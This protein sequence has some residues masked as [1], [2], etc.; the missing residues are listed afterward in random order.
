MKLGL[1]PASAHLT[2]FGARRRNG[3][4]GDV[5]DFRHSPLTKLS[6]KAMIKSMSH[7]RSWGEALSRNSLCGGE[8]ACINGGK[9]AS[10]FT[11]ELALNRDKKVDLGVSRAAGLI[12]NWDVRGVKNL[13]A[14]KTDWDDTCVDKGRAFS[15]GI[16]S[17]FCLAE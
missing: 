10:K 7:G 9:S 17:A 12:V 8:D 15:L 14:L 6:P 13:E 11:D 16:F 5:S 1:R 3:E 4:A 2:K